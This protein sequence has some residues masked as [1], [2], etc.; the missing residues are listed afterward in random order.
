MLQ[1][2]RYAVVGV[3]VTLSLM[4]PISTAIAYSGPTHK[5]IVINAVEYIIASCR[6]TTP[7]VD[8]SAGK[9]DYDLLHSTLAPGLRKPSDFN[10]RLRSFALLLGE[11]SDHTDRFQDVWLKF[12]GLLGT[13]CAASAFGISFTTL[14]HF[15]NVRTPGLLWDHGGY[16]YG[17]VAEN[18]RCSDPGFED[19]IVNFF[20]Q[21]TKATIDVRKS[22]AIIRYRDPL[23]SNVDPG[24]YFE[25]FE[26]K[27]KHI[28]FW[29]L[30][31]LAKYWFDGFV[32]TPRAHDNTPLNLSW[33]GPVLHAVADATVPYHAAGLSG[34]GHSAYEGVVEA[35]HENGHLYDQD[36]VRRHLIRAAHLKTSLDISEIVLGNATIAGD[37]RFCEC[38]VGSCD[39]PIVR[40][41]IAAR[42]L[43]NL[44]VASTV[45]V[46]RK[47][48]GE[49]KRQQTQVRA[50]GIPLKVGR[51]MRPER[52][53]YRNLFE[54]P[55]V[56]PKV[57]AFN[58]DYAIAMQKKL[59]IHLQKMKN[60][61]G[62][63]EL[64]KIGK[65][66]FLKDFEKVISDTATVVAEFPDAIWNPLLTD[67][68]LVRHSG[69][70][71]IGDPA[72]RFRLPT[73]GEIRNDKKWA[74]YRTQRRRFFEAK[75]IYN[76][77]ELRGALEGKL[78]MSLS[79]LEKKEIESYICDLK[80]LQ[81]VHVGSMVQ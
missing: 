10:Q 8:N 61:V 67:I 58:L 46:I 71:P 19:V 13:S 81:G 38:T 44:A 30:T 42:E 36:E 45:M 22:D 70:P 75:G 4:V 41:E 60:I 34:C 31:N 78:Q 39:C 6:D 57:V 26:Q 49:W 72:I 47:A 29:P 48:L 73:L 79:D 18:Q 43:Y 40:N 12:P 69:L 64:R 56:Q 74:E 50:A 37:S 63:F 7:Y 25:H 51:E 11:S 28:H 9:F 77:G 27:I 54:V 3:I 33:L 17:W 66:A 65:E 76:I 15:I 21:N 35:L 68:G 59:V 2:Q 52:L 23:R 62:S 55:L 24:Q 20:I 80:N 32:K 16:Y 53:L 14:S 1:G 5:K